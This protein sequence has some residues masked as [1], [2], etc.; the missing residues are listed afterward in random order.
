LGGPIHLVIELSQRP[1]SARCQNAED[2]REEKSAAETLIHARP[3]ELTRFCN[4]AIQADTWQVYHRSPAGPSRS[5]D[6]LTDFLSP[7]P[8]KT[9]QSS[10]MWQ[11]PNL[12]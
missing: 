7:M 8:N 9:L 6:N 11:V 4:T 3:P 5:F 10:W 12:G 1:R 2:R